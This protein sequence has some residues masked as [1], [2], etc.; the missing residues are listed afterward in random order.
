VKKSI[1][2]VPTMTEENGK[3]QSIVF[4]LEHAKL[5]I[6]ALGLLTLVLG[7]CQWREGNRVATEVAYQHLTK[8][9]RDHLGLFISEPEL[10]PYFEAKKPLLPANGKLREK[11]LAVADVRLDAIEAIL[12]YGSF[13]WSDKDMD[14]WVSTFQRAFDRSTVLCDRIKDAWM[15]YG[16]AKR[17]GRNCAPRQI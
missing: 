15:D 8:V 12:T 9:W 1:G 3:W 17:P 4:N 2:V 7:V 10:R 14:G 16:Q 5:A 13:R 11:V 6:A